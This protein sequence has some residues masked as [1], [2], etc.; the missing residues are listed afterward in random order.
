MHLTV[1]AI[2]DGV[3]TKAAG[4]C[5]EHRVQIGRHVQIEVGLTERRQC[6]G[7]VGRTLRERRAFDLEVALDAADRDRAI[8]GVGGMEREPDLLLL[9]VCLLYTSRCV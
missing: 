7:G 1:H 6:E 9:Y 3:V 2:V 4:Q 5:R 8:V